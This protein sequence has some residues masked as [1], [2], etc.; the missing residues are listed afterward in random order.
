MQGT[1]FSEHFGGASHFRFID[2]NRVTGNI[3]GHIDMPAPEHVPGAFPQWL[4]QQGVKAVGLMVEVHNSPE[5]AKSDGEQALLPEE[6]GCLMSR[7]RAVAQA[8]GRGL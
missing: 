2:A 4:A 5:H 6:F 8:V 3:V 1:V 7:V